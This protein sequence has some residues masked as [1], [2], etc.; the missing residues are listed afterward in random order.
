MEPVVLANVPLGHGTQ[1]EILEDP[2]ENEPSGQSPEGEDN[3]VPTQCLPGG[4]ELHEDDPNEEKLPE[5]QE[6]DT[7]ESPDCEQK[8]PDKHGRHETMPTTD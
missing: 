7:D 8:Y 6:P 5:E 4:Q 1:E 2:G 3:E